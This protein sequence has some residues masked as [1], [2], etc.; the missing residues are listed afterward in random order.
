MPLNYLPLGNK[1]FIGSYSTI[2]PTTATYTDASS[3]IILNLS[4]PFTSYNLTR[5]NITAGNTQTAF[6][7]QT[8][9]TYTDTGLTANNNYSYQI[10]PINSSATGN[11][12][13]LGSICTYGYA[14][15]TSITTTTS[16]VVFNWS[17]VY[18]TITITRSGG[19][20]ILGTLTNYPS[21]NGQTVVTGSATDSNL[22]D[23]TTYNYTITIT[24]SAGLTSYA[25]YNGAVTSLNSISV[26]TPSQA[27]YV[28]G[29]VMPLPSTGTTGANTT[30]LTSASTAITGI[31][32]TLSF[33]NGT[34]SASSSSNGAG[35]V[36]YT[37]FSSSTSNFWICNYGG[38]SYGQ[39]AYS[40]YVYQ[41]GINPTVYVTTTVSGSTVAGEWLQL[42]FPY[43]FVLTGHGWLQRPGYSYEWIGLNYTVAGSNDGTTWTQVLKKIYTLGTLPPASNGSYIE[44]ITGNVAYSYYRLI[45]TSAMNDSGANWYGSKWYLYG[46]K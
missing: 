35:T 27:V 45:C 39:N 29:T 22:A 7:G 40:N 5:T 2:F 10:V 11:P 23:Y 19:T 26:T 13:N 18:N 6:N 31:T 25:W 8:T 34:Y 3:S 17:G 30:T 46:T 44:T 20:P 12:V 1:Y 33:M 9:K 28:N 42:Q 21:G 24:N 37:M 43:S 14:T 32:G 41:G 38:N 15:I 16:T 4:G 36:P